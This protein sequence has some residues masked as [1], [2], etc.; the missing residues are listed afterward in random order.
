[1]QFLICL[2]LSFVLSVPL[3]MITFYSHVKLMNYNVDMDKLG[4]V[5][6]KAV[7]PS[8]WFVLLLFMYFI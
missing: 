6:A 5:Y 7:G 3:M 1:M 4:K 2:L 8:I